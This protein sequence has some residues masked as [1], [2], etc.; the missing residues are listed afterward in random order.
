MTLEQRRA[1]LVAQ[2]EKLIGSINA[3][4]GAMQMLDILIQDRDKPAEP[5]TE[6]LPEVPAS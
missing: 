6:P 5:P 1:E 4:E 3:V 2:K